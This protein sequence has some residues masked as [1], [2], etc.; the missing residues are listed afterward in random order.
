MNKLYFEDLPFVHNGKVKNG[1]WKVIKNHKIYADWLG[2]TLGYKKP[3]D[4]YQI[5]LKLIKDN[6]GA[7]LLTHYYHDSP[8]LFVKTMFPDYE[9]FE[10][11]FTVTPNGFWKD[12][13]NH[14]R[15]IKWL[16]EK[17]EYKEPE[18][19]YQITNKLINDNSGCGL[20]KNY[21]K[22]NIKLFMKAM[23]PNY[24][25]FEWLFSD[26][27]HNFWKDVKNHKRYIKW[28]GEKLGYEKSEDW[29]QI[30]Q[31]LIHD[32]S[33]A[34][35]LYLYY[36]ASPFLF[37]KT[38][39]PNDEWF[40]WLFN[41]APTGTWEDVKNHKRY[42]KWLGKKLGYKEPKDW[43]QITL[44]LVHNNYGAGLLVTYYNDS[45]SLFVKTI[46]PNNEWFEWLFIVAPQGFW[47]DVK[48]HKRYVKWLG[49]KLGYEKPEDWYQI[50]TKLIYD[51][52][53]CGLLRTYYND[54]ASLF[55][56]TMFPNDEWFEWLF[57][58][59]PQSTWIVV[60]NH[61]RYVKWLG[62]KLG[63]E[64]PEDWYQITTKLIYDNSGCGL[65]KIYND[66]PSLF[67]KAMFPDYE[68]EK[69]KF[70]KNYSAGQI[71]WAGFLKITIPDIRHALNHVD[72]E[73]IIP[74][75]RYQADGYSEKENT[76]FEYHG[77]QWHGNPKLYDPTKIFSLVNKTY[78]TLYDNT[79]KKQKY[80]EDAGYKY[81]FIW[82]SDWIRGKNA[83]KRIQK[84]FREKM[85]N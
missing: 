55:V 42:A 77:D 75:T 48:N 10:W 49:K 65:L 39:F 52:S 18:D 1:A 27:G 76:I 5:N 68:W 12:V 51:N 46:F 72:G 31:K 70:W 28:L 11:L 67:V 8:S 71:E 24:E 23:F 64:K 81:Y 43:Y 56:K 40:E 83:V 26:V 79:L 16:G 62:K 33:G 15:Y 21:Y 22:S 35:L 78:G 44:K 38:M 53:G 19:W 41:V 17:L 74:N 60:K 50:T 29:Y 54:S 6:Y 66:S 58:K 14:K 47:K 30:T 2:E 82:E 84:I 63:Y 80:C 45:A 69:S 7:G 3:E 34:G 36:S 37:V 25:W 4:W 85:R 20:I 57:T 61:K 73:Y 32:N 59:A 13:K 9:W